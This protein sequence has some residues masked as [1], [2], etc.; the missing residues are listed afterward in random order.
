MAKKKIKI[1]YFSDS[2]SVSY[3]VIITL[4]TIFLY[5][6]ILYYAARGNIYYRNSVDLFIRTLLDLSGIPPKVGSIVL[7]LLICS[8]ICLHRR[9]SLSIKIQYFPI[10][11]FESSVYAFTVGLM[12]SKLSRFIMLSAAST[13]QPLLIQIGLALGAGGYEELIFRA[14]FFYYT[15]FMLIEGGGMRC[16]PAYYIAALFSSAV[17]VWIHYW[18]MPFDLYSALFRF[19][20]AL[21]FCILYYLRGLGV[22]T[23]THVFYDFFVIYTNNF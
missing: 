16:E 5:R 7:V 13:D 18:N 4:L 17:F 1:S 12:V 21:M 23:L 19:L 14:L 22:T 20:A 11:I 10:M 9:P 3:G 2:R 15:A 8:A 6:T